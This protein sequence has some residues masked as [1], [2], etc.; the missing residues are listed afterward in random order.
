MPTPTCLRLKGYVVVVVKSVQ[1]QFMTW[2]HLR[3]CIQQCQLSSPKIAWSMKFQLQTHIY[4]TA[5]NTCLLLPSFHTRNVLF[6]IYLRSLRLFSN[7]DSF[8][9]QCAQVKTCLANWKWQ[10]IA[11]DLTNF[12]C[13]QFVSFLYFFHTQYRFPFKSN[14]NIHGVQ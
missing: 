10:T 12:S 4:T 5:G 9:L 7:V 1:L 8:H 14:M 3:D 11:F 2:W 6:V 13:A